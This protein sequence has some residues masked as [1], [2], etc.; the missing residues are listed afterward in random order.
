[1]LL[2]SQGEGFTLHRSNSFCFGWPSLTWRKLILLIINELLLLHPFNGLFSRTTWVSRDQKDKTS[3]RQEIMGFRDGSVISWTMCKQSA[4]RCRQTTTPRPRHT[5][6]T[7][8]MLC[9]TPNRQCQSTE[10]VIINEKLSYCGYCRTC[11]H[12]TEL[13]AL[14]SR[15]R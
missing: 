2:V 11:K 5:T 1:M 9:I 14:A 13:T 8:Q 6:F 4:P 15:T 7:G 10:G 12:K 3:L